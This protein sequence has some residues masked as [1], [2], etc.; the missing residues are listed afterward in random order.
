MQVIPSDKSNINGVS[1]VN[2]TIGH[3]PSWPAVGL[4]EGAIG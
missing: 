4:S 1:F 3:L 2:G